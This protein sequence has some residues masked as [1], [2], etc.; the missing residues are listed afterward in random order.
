LGGYDIYWTE[1]RTHLKNSVN[2][3][4]WLTIKYWEKRDILGDKFESTDPE[5]DVDSGLVHTT[6]GSRFC[7]GAFTNQYRNKEIK[8]VQK[9]I[10]KGNGIKIFD[11]NQQC[12]VK[13][14]M[15]FEM[16]ICSMKGSQK[17]T[18][19]QQCLRCIS[20][21][22]GVFIQSLNYNRSLDLDDRH[23][24]KVPVGQSINIF[25]FASFR[26]RLQENGCIF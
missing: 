25:D 22:K 8:D 16:G 19:S 5:V 10:G 20:L 3:Q 7:F 14:N 9:F 24:E 11:Q 6:S 1:V 17:C 23:V 21:Q 4:P 2:R 12:I 15:N 26:R 13:N 18:G